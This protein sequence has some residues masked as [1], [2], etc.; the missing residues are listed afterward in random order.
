[1]HRSKLIFRCLSTLILL[2]LFTSSC[3]VS[4]NQGSP[5]PPSD[6][7][8][9][10]V[11]SSLPLPEF[12]NSLTGDVSADYSWSATDLAGKKVQASDWKGKVVILNMWATWC[13]PCVAEMPSLQNLYN[14][15]KS[16]GYVFVFVSNE[17]QET[18]N[19]FTQKKNY[20]LPIYTISENLP[21]VFSTDAIPKTFVISPTGKIVFEH[22]GGANW[23][24][25]K[26]I[27][28]LKSVAQLK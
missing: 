21:S 3:D 11:S 15:T 12:P 28:F 20:S 8:I 2:V 10:K 13:G 7:E 16:D 14:K 1:M 6:E 19:T 22:L 18:V 25:Q 24:D 17:D 27:D 26:T 5:P 4:I 23:D 9:K